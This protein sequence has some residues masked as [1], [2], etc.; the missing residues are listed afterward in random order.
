MKTIRDSWLI[1]AH[2]T[3]ISF[4][5]V[6]LMAAVLINPLFYLFLFGPLLNKVSSLPGFPVAGGYDS[7]VPGLLIQI[8]LFGSAFV[9]FG[10]L[11]QWRFGVL[12]RLRVGPA[13]RFAVIAGNVGKESINLLTQALIVML[14][15]IPLGLHVK[16]FGIVATC[17]L[18]L[19][20]GIMFGSFSIAVALT[21]RNESTLAPII[22]TIV[23]PLLLL[24]GVLLPMNLA[25]NWLAWISAVN[26]LKYSV[27]AARALFNEDFMSV[28][29]ARGLIVTVLLAAMTFFWAMRSYSKLES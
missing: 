2:E 21:L 27:D 12:E 5:Q 9:G 17:V 13:S 26:P 8:G 3:G 4:R 22:N 11:T 25:P 28:D 14:L 23:I 20:L 24:S 15:G 18:V 7:F 1:F 10:I 19:L 29:A 16:L 6:P